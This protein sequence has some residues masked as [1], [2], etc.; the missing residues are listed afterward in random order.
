MAASPQRRDTI[1]T[2]AGSEA[3]VSDTCR[4]CRSE[5]TIEEPL[6]YPCKCSGSIKFVHQECLMEWL[7]HS[8]K[9]HCELCKTPFRFTKLYDADMPQV[10]PWT[11][12]VQRACLHVAFMILRA[13][14]A[15][16]VSAVWLLLL[17]WLIRW[18]WRWMFWVA[19]VGWARESFV[20]QMQIERL[21]QLQNINST[22]D[23]PQTAQVESLKYWESKFGKIKGDTALKASAWILAQL[24]KDS[25]APMDSLNSTIFGPVSVSWPQADSSILSGFS[26][27][28]E[29]T[30]NSGLNRI[31]LDVFEGQLITC[32]VI[33]GFVLVFLI[34]EWV[35]QQQ[36]LVNLDNLNIEVQAR[37]RQERRARDRMRRQLDLLDQARAQANALEN[38]LAAAQESIA[39]AEAARPA[40]SVA[41]EEH[42]TIDLENVEDLVNAVSA[43]YHDLDGRAAFA[44]D[45]IKLIRDIHFTEGAEP[46]GRPDDS[47]E[48][49]ERSDARLEEEYG[50]HTNNPFHPDGPDPDNRDRDT[51]RDRPA[52]AEAAPADEGADAASEHSAETTVPVPQP[53]AAPP[54]FLQRTAN[55]FWGDIQ[56][57][58]RGPDPVPVPQE[59][60][61]DPAE[62]LVEIPDVPDA[63]ADIFFGGAAAQQAGLDPEAIEDVDDLEGIFELIG[64]HG[65]IIGL[66]QTS[67]FCSVLVSATIAGAVGLPYL[68]G[69]VVLSFIGNPLGFILRVPLQTASIAADFLIDAFLFIGGWLV[70]L[71]TFVAGIILS[72]ISSVAKSAFM[73]R[74]SDFGLTTAEHAL[75]R[76]EK[77]L[78]ASE[79]SIE[80]NWNSA[81]LKWSIHAHDSLVTIQDEVNFVLN[82]IGSVIT[83]VVDTISSGSM[84]LVWQRS[85]NAMAHVLE[86]PARLLAGVEALE[87]YTR[88]FFDIIRNLRTGALTFRVSEVSLEPTLVYW[89]S[90]DRG[91]AVMTGYVALAALAAIYVALDTPIMRTESG[92][93]T[94]KIVR[95]TLRQ[96]GGVLK[97]ILIISIE[98]LVFPLYCGLLLDLAFLPLFQGAS[99]ATRWAF[100]VRAPYTFC[101]VH[102]FI[103]T[104]YMFHFALF[105]GMCRKI[106]RKGV[107]WFIRDPDDPTFHPVRD[108]LERNVTTQLRKIVFSALVYGALVILCLGGV[109]WS[110]GHI[111]EGIFPI[112]WISTEPVLEFPMDLLLYN[113]LT[114]LLIKLF[115]PSDAV[116]AMYAWWLR[117]CARA[118][119]LSHFLFDDRR[120]DEEG[121]HV[122]KSWITRLLLRRGN[123][124]AALPEDHHLDA[125][126]ESTPDVYFQRD[127]KYVLTPCSDQY[128]PPKPGEA[129]LYATDND[130]YIADKDGNKNDHF[131]RVYIP[132]SFQLRVTLFMVCLWM[133]S[134]FTG[135]CATLVPLVFGRHLFGLFVPAGVQVNDIYAYSVGAYIIFGALYAGYK[136]NS[137][138]RY[139]Q[140]NA[141]IVDV[142]AWLS[143]VA[144]NVTQAL[145]CLYV[146]GFL[147][148]VLPIAFALIIQFYLILPIHTLLVASASTLA[149]HVLADY[150]L[151]LLY[152]RIAIR[153][154]LSTP[155]SRAAEAFRRITA[156]GYL[157]PDARLATRFFV[158]PATIL[159]LVVL[160]APLTVAHTLIVVIN[161]FRRNAL[162]TRTQ[163]V[164]Y[165]YA[166]PLMAIN[167]VLWIVLRSAANATARWRARIRDEVYLVGERLHNF[168]E[169]RPP[170]GSRSVVRKDR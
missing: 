168:G 126:D 143:S 30:K 153:F 111:F 42:E 114:P 156:N 83:S 121:R 9:K 72:P 107:L 75:T 65:P 73:G 57:L 7:S 76:V 39:A 116:H 113:F 118:L 159:A 38:E 161:L 146:Y 77:L 122:H 51:F 64:L 37:Q 2:I 23:L 54:S 106:L 34:R 62:P 40:E 136:Y 152:V 46:D 71:A 4:I 50:P 69:K 98:M 55:W 17:P 129:F 154:I 140:D 105:V 87:Q 139:L 47:F 150:A 82:Y 61:I 29:L 142:K 88:P 91:L 21:L 19:D 12:F 14:R 127:G 163:A 6:F 16:L 102:W 89:N 66:F 100:A 70:V 5:G 149:M 141:F 53:P 68:W 103:G 49:A 158:L 13:C 115:K 101:F 74:V 134:A 32:V 148:V 104:C 20:R 155:T 93:K 8:H 133:F 90:T 138:I 165:R 124:D 43:K 63:N 147:G 79:S 131:S 96:A 119:R 109:I 10:L 33:T 3:G 130:A 169:K 15:L 167:I 84:A 78:F 160:V 31:I 120:K 1:S 99:M 125:H 151:G 45:A 123:V 44:A 35:V 58:E 11:V 18:S 59:E 157:D 128:R 27:L 95:D 92:Q 170:V 67:C 86:F 26:Y 41:S 94:E 166:Y 22:M 24:G 85:V 117:R 36:P 132:P 164:I 145:K 56:L 80:L 52:A 112:Q 97:V 110:I 108:V 60:R 25:D 48:A 137:A 144:R 28:S 81:F 162:A 135:L